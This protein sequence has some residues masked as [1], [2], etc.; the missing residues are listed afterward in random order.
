M[1]PYLFYFFNVPFYSTSLNINQCIMSVFH[2]WYAS[3][4]PDLN[5]YCLQNNSTLEGLYFFKEILWQYVHT[6]PLSLGNAGTMQLNLA[7]N[8]LNLKSPIPIYRKAVLKFNYMYN[9]NIVTF[10]VY[11]HIMYIIAQ[12]IGR[13]VEITG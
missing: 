1:F 10:N 6:C 7:T 12:Y 13:Q 11:L 4:N 9:W 2:L 3:N 8:C 5:F